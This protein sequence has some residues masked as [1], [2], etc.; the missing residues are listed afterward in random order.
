MSILT[1]GELTDSHIEVLPSPYGLLWLNRISLER[2]QSIRSSFQIASHKRCHYR[3]P[4]ARS[5]SFLANS[6]RGPWASEFISLWPPFLFI[7]HSQYRSTPWRPIITIQTLALIH[8]VF[9]THKST[10]LISINFNF[11]QVSARANES[12]N[13]DGHCRIKSPCVVNSNCDASIAS[14]LMSGDSRKT[15][16]MLLNYFSQACTSRKSFLCLV[17]INSTSPW[18]NQPACHQHRI[19]AAKSPGNDTNDSSTNCVFQRHT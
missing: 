2:V 5:S 1:L 15:L 12:W 13:W 6:I 10:H 17:L 7:Q 8:K 9:W 19:L 18:Y 16:G 3:H 14:I 4:I 11:S